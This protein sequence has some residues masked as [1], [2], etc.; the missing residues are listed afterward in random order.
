MVHGDN[1]FPLIE[2]IENDQD[3]VNR[4]NIATIKQ[5]LRYVFG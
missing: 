4:F 3:L 5:C 2:M 1:L